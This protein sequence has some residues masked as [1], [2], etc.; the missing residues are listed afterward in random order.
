MTQYSLILILY[1][2]P[3]NIIMK[4]KSTHN[5]NIGTEMMEISSFN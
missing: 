5:I 4:V 2:Y 3:I 1:K